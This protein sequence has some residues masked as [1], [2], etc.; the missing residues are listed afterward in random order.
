MTRIIF[1]VFL[2]FT[3]IPNSLAAPMTL[4]GIQGDV[5]V[6]K[7][8]AKDW[9]PAQEKMEVEAGDQ[10]KTGEKSA[11]EIQI[12]K[13]SLSLG[14]KTQFGVKRYEVGKEEWVTASLELTLGRLKAQV[15]KMKKG[16]ELP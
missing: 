8:G 2:F 16:S 1:G 3:A 15:K 10:L 13:G 5:R 14:E 11:V 6:L 9:V 12:E 4:G 7:H